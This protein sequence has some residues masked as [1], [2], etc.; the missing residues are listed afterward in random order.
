MNCRQK[1]F[2]ISS[3]HNRLLYELALTCSQIAGMDD[4]FELLIPALC[5]D[6][7]T[8]SIKS[9]TSTIVSLDK[10][11]SATNEGT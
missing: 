5:I 2:D 9:S 10:Y 3:H 8:K 11:D 1:I 7:D 6:D 4:K